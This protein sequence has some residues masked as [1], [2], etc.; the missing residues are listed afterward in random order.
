MILH[1]VSIYPPEDDEI[2]L[3][4]IDT[5]SG[6]YEYPVGFSDHTLGTAIPIAAIAKARSFDRETLYIRSNNGGGGIARYLLHLM[7]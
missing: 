3:C 6:M 7:S 4:N 5:L 1:C 2:N